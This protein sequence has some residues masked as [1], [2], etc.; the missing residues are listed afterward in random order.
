MLLLKKFTPVSF[1]ERLPNLRL[2]MPIRVVFST[3]VAAKAT[4]KEK[5]PGLAIMI[6]VEQ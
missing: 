3:E 4:G 6:I 2:R 5:A 1:L